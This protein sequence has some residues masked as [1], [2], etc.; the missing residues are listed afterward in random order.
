M[1]L[2]ESSLE[3]RSS[4][5][6][7][8]VP[9]Q[10]PP[11]TEADV[12]ADELRV[13]RLEAERALASTKAP[14]WRR[15]DPLTLAILAGAASLVGNM[16]V[17]HIK[18][19]DDLA[20]EQA[21][22]RYSLVLQAMATNDAAV[23]KRNIHFFI[24]AGLLTDADCRIR[25]AIDSDNPVLP[26]L[27]GTAPPGVTNSLSTPLIA[28]LY[29]FP[30]GLDGR[31]QTI[32]ILALGSG[33]D[34]NDLEK[35]FSG[36]RLPV[37]DVKIVSVDGGTNQPSGQRLMDEEATMNIE[38]AGGI[39]PRANLSVY[40]APNTSAD[41]AQ[42]IQQ[43]TADKVSVLLIGY[44]TSE[45]HWEDKDL[46]LME[47]ALEQAA[48]QG[49]TVVVAAGDRGVT[50]GVSDKRRH[51][52]YPASSP[53]VLG[54]GGTTLQLEK[55]HIK[56]EKVWSEGDAFATGGGVSEKF[57]RPDWQTVEVPRRAD[58]TFGRGVP[59][60]VAVADPTFGYAL[61]VHGNTIKLGGTSAA[62]PLWGGLIALL[63]QA[64]GRN[65]GYLNP[66][67]YR[68]LGPAG[69]LR[70]I[71]EGDNGVS[72]VPG[73]KAG[74]GWSPVAGWGRPDGAKLINWL[75]SH[76]D[77]PVNEKKTDAC[78]IASTP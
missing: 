72:G 3:L 45:N 51:V 62:V 38:I 6:T 5:M 61:I 65:V 59:D 55:D 49:V 73:F 74:P 37:P 50:D 24:D 78:Q 67:L 39:A 33:F 56:S 16:V 10:G 43:A 13:R 11:P 41:F 35:Y 18:A 44:G 27:S 46:K 19:G 58:N 8:V 1:A 71:T 29:N 30:P 15:A 7:D 28:S 20:L 69:L 21:K 40:F 42:A 52:D 54:V 68:E 12:K 48:K 66:R 25:N 76:P 23:A 34:R 53:W 63:N 31:G 77:G 2:Q 17:T 60:V 47:S 64:V 70:E 22:A 75:R 14:W 4:D 36:L 57:P 9:N 26:S 32:G